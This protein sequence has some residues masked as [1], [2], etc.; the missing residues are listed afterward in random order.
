MIVRICQEKRKM[1]INE[2]CGSLDEALVYLCE[3]SFNQFSSGFFS[4]GLLQLSGCFYQGV[5][6]YAVAGICPV[7]L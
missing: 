4:Q 5:G 6:F 1:F 3:N 7:S 2:V